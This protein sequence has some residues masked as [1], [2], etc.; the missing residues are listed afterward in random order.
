MAMSVSANKKKQKNAFYFFMMDFKKKSEDK[1]LVFSGQKELAQ[2][3]TPFWD[4]LEPQNKWMFEEEA[5]KVREIEGINME[6]YTCQGKS[7]VQLERE[8][9]EETEKYMNM[10][11]EIE[12]T[13]RSLNVSTTLRTHV[14]YTIHVNY[15]CR[16]ECGMYTPC[17][18][19]LAAFNFADGV[20]ET[21]HTLINPGHIPLGYKFDAHKTS[22]E[23]HNIPVPP[24]DF[25]GETNYQKIFTS[26]KQFLTRRVMSPVFTLPENIEAVKNVL[27]QLQES[28]NPDLE[29]MFH[30]YPLTKLFYELRNLSASS[31]NSIGFSEFSLAENELE[32]DDFSF[33]RGL[34]CDFH[35]GSDALP[36]CSLL[37]V[38]SWI[39]LIM[40]S[41]CKDLGIDLKPGLHCPVD[42]NTKLFEREKEQANKLKDLSQDFGNLLLTPSASIYKSASR[43]TKMHSAPSTDLRIKN[44]QLK[45]ND[46]AYASKKQMPSIECETVSSDAKEVKKSLHPLRLPKSLPMALKS[47]LQ[48]KDSKT[49]NQ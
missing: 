5:R 31:S 26:I 35:K 19:A 1:G 27:W 14:F 25:K 22:E 44:V 10:M 46:G 23:T 8:M 6:K 29:D 24:E 40:K 28:V 43:L 2:K 21:Y 17:E 20:K 3:A 7:H 48:F 47:H 36:Y 13:V 12:N 49:V 37:H 39:F 33:A 9:K 41:C 42:V 15:Y 18:I 16:Q 11:Y 45:Q 38:K 30:V 34:A 32:R 4:T